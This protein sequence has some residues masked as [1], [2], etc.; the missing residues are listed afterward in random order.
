MTVHFTLEQIAAK[1]N[2][3]LEE[4]VTPCFILLDDAPI[5]YCQLYPTDAESYGCPP[6][7][8]HQHVSPDARCFGIDLFLDPSHRDQGL[9]RKVV[10]LLSCFLFTQQN[11]QVVLIDPKVHNARA[12]ACYKACGFQELFIVP[13]REEQDGIRHDSLIMALHRLESLPALASLR[14][15]E[16]TKFNINPH[17]PK[18]G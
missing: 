17:P 6:E 1:Y 11:A 4:R 7:Q 10:S 15:S 16:Y 18:E 13:Q 14:E 12:I 5:G 8:L 3:R 2:R 9:G